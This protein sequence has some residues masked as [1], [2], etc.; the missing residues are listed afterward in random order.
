MHFVPLCFHRSVR[1]SSVEER[2]QLI[3]ETLL[4]PWS[5]GQSLNSLPDPVLHTRTH[6]FTH[7]HP[8]AVIFTRLG[9][10]GHFVANAHCCVQI[11]LE[12]SQKKAVLRT[13]CL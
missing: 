6:T 9:K 3:F 4:P 12:D 10:V 5:L 7:T 13:V 8:K 11:L 1:H 2:L